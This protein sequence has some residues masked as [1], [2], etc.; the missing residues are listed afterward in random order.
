MSKYE[1]IQVPEAQLTPADNI[2]KPKRAKKARG[3]FFGVLVRLTIAG[4]L[5]GAIFGIAQI[6]TPFT[7]TITDTI[8]NAVT[9]SFSQG[10]YVSGR[11]EFLFDSL[12]NR[13][14]E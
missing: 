11:D 10:G 6:D 4:V 9:T 14:R 2:K 7:N 5:L 13:W 3:F 1:G 8:R 12:L